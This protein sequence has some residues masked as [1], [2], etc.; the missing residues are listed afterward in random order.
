MSDNIIST[1]AEERSVQVAVNTFMCDVYTW[2]TAGL[3]ATG[4][5]AWY[6][7]V[8]NPEFIV[9]HASW[10][11]PLIVIELLLVLAIGW[12]IDKISPAVAGIMF[13]VYAVL[14]G[15][16]LSWIFL[17]YELGSVGTIFLVTAGTFGGMS[18]FGYITKR[19]LTGIGSLCMMGLWGL[20]ISAVVN[21][22]WK[23]DMLQFMTSCVG[24][25]VFV[26]LTAYDTQKI[27]MIA[28]ASADGE[29]TGANARKL[30]VLG[31]LTLYLDFINLFLY[32][33]RLFGRRK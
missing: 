25:V 11:T 21:I 14:N 29:I 7:G 4:V 23:N 3:A 30:A 10:F 24:V 20:V 1:G 6:L 26:G 13:A 32:L 17:A 9:Q 28:L 27:K 22:F 18:L 33:L 2:M 8:K 16:T 5:V 19:D 31:A 12:M 15:M